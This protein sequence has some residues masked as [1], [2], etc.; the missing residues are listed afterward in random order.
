MKKDYKSH[1][2]AVTNKSVSLVVKQNKLFTHSFIQELPF[3]SDDIFIGPRNVLE[4]DSNFKHIIPYILIE[5][6]GKYL[7]YQRTSKSGESRLHG[8][9]S[10]GFGGH[11]DIG[12]VVTQNSNQQINLL[13]TIFKSATR[14]TTE[15]LSINFNTD[16]LNSTFEI[17]GFLNDDSNEVGLVHFGLVLKLRLKSGINIS[18]PENQIDLKGFKTIDELYQTNTDYENWSNALI[19]YMKIDII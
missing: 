5:Q 14:E 19:H 6:D 3:H 2:L 13:E 12:D 15:E 17:F 8:S 9:Y 4:F 16:V 18:S 11:I 7:S 1:I 10:I